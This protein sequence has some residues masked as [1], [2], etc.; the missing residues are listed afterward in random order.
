MI[1]PNNTTTSAFTLGITALAGLCFATPSVS[2]S[3]TPAISAWQSAAEI[4]T[5]ADV[6][7]G[8]LP[9]AGNKAD[10]ENESIGFFRIPTLSAHDQGAILYVGLR[11]EHAPTGSEFRAPLY[12]GSV[13]SFRLGVA[14]AQPAPQTVGDIGEIYPEDAQPIPVAYIVYRLDFSTRNEGVALFA[15]PTISTEPLTIGSPEFLDASFAWETIR[16]TNSP[17][18]DSRD[19]EWKIQNSG[20]RSAGRVA[21]PEPTSAVLLGLGALG[22]AARRRRA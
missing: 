15:T 5:G 6:F 16:F 13:E 7:T 3:E 11:A 20:N 4:R 10:I 19:A 2:A 1:R 17:D 8:T 12:S 22:L 21:A 9:V 18:T 14:E